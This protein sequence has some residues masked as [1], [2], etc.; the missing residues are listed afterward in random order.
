MFDFV[1]WAIHALGATVSVG[2]GSH[3]VVYL[4]SPFPSD[5]P[6]ANIVFE[7]HTGRVYTD[8]PSTMWLDSE[9]PKQWRDVLAGDNP[10]A[11]KLAKSYPCGKLECCLFRGE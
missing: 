7:L 4:T 3:I 11:V 10:K 8:Y 2:N 9:D 1:H 5:R 6:R